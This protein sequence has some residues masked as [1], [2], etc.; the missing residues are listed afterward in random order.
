V[1][2]AA[3]KVVCPGFIDVHSHSDIR[4]LRRPFGEEKLMQGVTTEI[5]GNC[6]LSP[7]PM[8]KDTSAMLKSFN[9]AFF[10]EIE[11]IWTWDTV[12]KYIDTLA[13]QKISNNVGV[14]VGNG[15][16]RIAVKGFDGSPVTPCEMKS[17]KRLLSDGME[18]GALGMSIGLLYTPQCFYSK[19]ELI[20]IS[21]VLG[22]HDGLLT[23]HI[24][25]EGNNLIESVKEVIE[26]AEKACIPLHISHFKAAGRNNWGLSL[27]SAMDLIEDYRSK[28]MDITCDVYPYTAGST[29]LLTLLPPWSQEGGT[30]RI[31]ERLRDKEIRRN[32]Y[33][34]LTEEQEDWDNLVYSTG[35]DQVYVTSVVSE[36]N[37]VYEGKSIAEISVSR[38]Q[39]AIECAFDL[40]L[41]ENTKV[42]IIFFHMCEEDVKKVIRWDQ[43]M[44]GSDS[45]G[46]FSGIPHP[47]LCGTFPRFFSKYVRE[48]KILSLEQAVR[49]VTSFPARKFK[50]K[51]RGLLIPGYV[52]DI[53][54]FDPDRIEDKATYQDPW[55]Y[56]IG[57]DTV[58][59]G[60][61]VTVK[62]SKHLG[63]TNGKVLLHGR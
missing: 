3:Q 20:D 47:R 40:L 37:K 4:I 28:G 41:E 56:P 27:D 6:G 32:M 25:G 30:E 10:G 33:K 55:Q 31:I 2:N 53:T 54:I 1:I 62:G 12:G 36:N 17:I 15:S 21:S 61:K 16:L 18:S 5:V 60:G 11:D 35:W 8:I 23:A 22:Y 45:V 24:R 42:G 63:E 19:D 44:I 58:I 26:I 29:S 51:E 57:I 39:D 48:E 43:S 52:A 46:S 34:E 38:N 9:E 59:V 50:L 13:Q 49:K 7:A 14:L